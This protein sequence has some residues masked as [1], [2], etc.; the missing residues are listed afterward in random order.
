MCLHPRGNTTPG[1]TNAS[2]V[3]P[4]IEEQSPMRFARVIRPALAGLAALTCLAAGPS[5][6]Q[7]SYT[8]SQTYTIPFDLT[9]PAGC[10]DSEGLRVRGILKERIV[11]TFS[12]ATGAK[13]TAVPDPSG[14]A[15]IGVTSGGSYD[16]TPAGS[17]IL[18]L[19]SKSSRTTMEL[20]Q[21]FVLSGQDDFGRPLPNDGCTL[22]LRFGATIVK[23]S[24][25]V[26][27][28]QA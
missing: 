1:G 25:T 26:N 20:D 17:V 6:A 14:L 7:T 15:V 10:P 27:W 8:S 16:L 2:R 12:N 3:S 24:A 13:V 4:Y 19:H 23:G 9:A 28:H 18:S 22:R 11:T 5:P 21:Q